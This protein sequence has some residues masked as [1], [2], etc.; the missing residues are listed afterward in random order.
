MTPPGPGSPVALGWPGGLDRALVELGWS[1]AQAACALEPRPR[2]WRLSAS[3]IGL[4]GPAERLLHPDERVRAARLRFEI[5]RQRYVAFHAALH[6][7]LGN[8]L[9]QPPE[10]LAWETGHHGKPA[11]PAGSPLAFNLSHSHDTGALVIGSSKLEWGIDV[12]ALR[13]V[14]D[15]VDVARRVFTPPELE[16]WKSWPSAHATAAFLTLWTR[17]EA[18]LKAI[19]SGFAVEPGRFTAGLATFGAPSGCRWR[20][21]T[22]PTPEGPDTTVLLHDLDAG[23]GVVAA[24][25]AWPGPAAP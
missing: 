10:A 17:K 1:A 20:R 7:V 22:L 9:G 4:A 21:V 18:C 16:A 24:V 13:P 3:Q 14:D 15:I 12:E 11:L 6:N 2:A 5:D 19:G 25:A 8:A 23:A